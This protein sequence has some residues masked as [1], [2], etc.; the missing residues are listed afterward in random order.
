[1][2][3]R[4]PTTENLVAQSARVATDTWQHLKALQRQIFRT[5]EQIRGACEDIQRSLD[6]L[7]KI[8]EQ[9]PG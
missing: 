3:R 9:G 4:W 5:N 6:L 8:D 7:K 2:D 1:M